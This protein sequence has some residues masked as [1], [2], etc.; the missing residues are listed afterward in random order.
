MSAGLL[1]D[2]CKGCKEDR[3]GLRNW[4]DACHERAGGQHFWKGLLSLVK[5]NLPECQHSQ[6]GVFIAN[7]V[8]F[9]VYGAISVGLYHSIPPFPSK[10]LALAFYFDPIASPRS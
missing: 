1:R 5:N 3:D 10:T 4:E 8:H 7:P 9:A 2:L 6:N